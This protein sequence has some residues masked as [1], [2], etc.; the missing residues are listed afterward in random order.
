MEAPSK[1]SLADALQSL[2]SF[3]YAEEDMLPFP[4]Q[5]NLPWPILACLNSCTNGQELLQ[6]ADKANQ[7]E[8]GDIDDWTAAETRWFDKGITRD[9]LLSISDDR[10]PFDAKIG[11]AGVPTTISMLATIF[12]HPKSQDNLGDVLDIFD[13]LSPG[14]KRSFVAITINWLLFIY[15]FEELSDEE[16]TY[17]SI[18]YQTLE[19][20]YREVPPGSVIP[21]FVIVNL[22]GDSIQRVA[23]FFQAFKYKNFELHAQS[24][25]RNR[26]E[27]SVTMLRRAYMKLD[28]GAVLLPILGELAEKGSL[29]GQHI[30]IKDPKSLETVEEKT[31]A[32]II[33]L[34]QETW[35]TDS[36]EQ[37]IASARE[38]VDSSGNVFNRIVTTLKSSRPTGEHVDKLVV[39]L[40]RLIPSDDLHANKSYVSLLE[41]VLRRRTSQ[42]ADPKEA[43][44]FALPEGVVELIR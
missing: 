41:D 11:E 25:S 42:F 31:A 13:S 12:T 26:E 29:A 39:A 5:G 9:D 6:L 37:L 23:E 38:I 1:R 14:K 27:E 2:A 4:Q 24:T 34:C 7:G 21:L 15:S 36:S 8:L 28:E 3:F 17:L 32:L 35:Q 19:S 40:K 16:S 10:L 20:I 22:I 18:D 43:Y 44:R 33:N 30:D